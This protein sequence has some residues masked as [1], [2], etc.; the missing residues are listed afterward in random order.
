M[1][2]YAPDIDVRRLIIIL[3][4]FTFP[5]SKEYQNCHKTETNKTIAKY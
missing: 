3:Y 1:K 4:C 2:Y 5:E